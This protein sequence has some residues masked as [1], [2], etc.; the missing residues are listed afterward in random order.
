[1]RPPPIVRLSSNG[2]VA[3]LFRV[4]HGSALRD[5]Q[6]DGAVRN[7]LDAGKHAPVLLIALHVIAVP[8]CVE[9]PPHGLV[10]D[11]PDLRNDGARA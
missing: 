8:R 10:G 2:R 11:F 3:H 9:H 1:M 5:V 6:C 7:E 4:L